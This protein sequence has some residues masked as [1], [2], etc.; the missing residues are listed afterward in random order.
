[1][2]VSPERVFLLAKASKAKYYTFSEFN[3]NI[4]SEINLSLPASENKPLDTDIEIIRDNSIPVPDAS[5]KFGNCFGD[6]SAYFY[7]KEHLFIAKICEGKKIFVQPL[8]DID[9]EV[10]S[11]MVLNIPLGY[12]LYQK[13]KFVL[14]G[15][16]F[17]KENNTVLFL[18]ES[19]SGKSSLVA[20]LMDSGE[21]LSE[22][23]CYIVF[24]KNGNSLVNP[25]LPFIKLEK[26]SNVG[27]KDNFVN[28]I[29]IPH[30]KRK[31]AYYY[32]HKVNPRLKSKIKCIYLLKWGDQFRIYKPD[33]EELFSFLNLC[34]FTCYPL[35]SCTNS[36][37]QLFENIT[38]LSKKTN[39]FIL[40][41]NK[42]DLF[43][44][45]SELLEHISDCP[46]II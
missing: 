39:Y 2:T 31:R 26:E 14:H 10:L 4:K 34:A 9:E 23:L 6:Q 27:F 32:F 12:C 44:N 21:V 16:G 17:K 20:S 8:S 33:I 38:K 13:S 3:L 45:N 19:G 41:R 37:K 15:S 7:L 43:A 22:D 36:S 30:D 28:I 35:N 40:E 18:G 24:D 5:N 46:E 29:D 42:K 25:F 11:N 1:M